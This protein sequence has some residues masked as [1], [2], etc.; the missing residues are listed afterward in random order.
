MFWPTNSACKSVDGLPV[1]ADLNPIRTNLE[2][3]SSADNTNA[4]LARFDQAFG[5]S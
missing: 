4:F 2:T 3:V 5:R 1:L